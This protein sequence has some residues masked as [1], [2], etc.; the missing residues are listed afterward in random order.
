MKTLFLLVSILL[1]VSLSVLSAL[2][3]RGL[4]AWSGAPP[5]SGEKTAAVPSLSPAPSA[6]AFAVFPEQA[7]LIEEILAGLAE[8]R[9]QYQK[10]LQELAEQESKFQERKI[11][12]ER[13]ELQ[14]KELQSKLETRIVEL[15]KAEAANFKRLA[16]MYA[17]MDPQGASNLLEQ[18]EPE[19]VAKI[20][21]FVPDRQAAAILDAAVARGDKGKSVAGSWS[22][23]LR[24]LNRQGRGT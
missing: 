24:R 18:M 19:R 6:P 12:L 8:E 10:K 11:I 15:E 1:A 7:R 21:A 17:K 20:L 13:I 3:A 9:R 4:M 2:L 5:A 22:D 14:V 23:A 16:E